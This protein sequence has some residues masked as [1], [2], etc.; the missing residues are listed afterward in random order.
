[1]S[2]VV[3]EVQARL[4]R[5]AGSFGNGVRV[6]KHRITLMNFADLGWKTADA[7]ELM[8]KICRLLGAEG[9]P[10]PVG[11]DAVVS[12]LSRVETFAQLPAADRVAFERIL[13]ALDVVLGGA[14]EE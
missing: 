8:W 1:V 4:L 9:I 10:V 12:G 2:D 13:K 3:E 5:R 14:G 11:W 6:G 7:V